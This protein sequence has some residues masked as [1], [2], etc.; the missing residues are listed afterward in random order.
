[1]SKTTNATPPRD[2]DWGERTIQSC[3]NYEAPGYWKSDAYE[4]GQRYA[5]TDIDVDEFTQKHEGRIVYPDLIIH[6]RDPTLTTTE[7]GT[8]CIIKGNKK[9]CGKSTLLKH[10]A[11]QMMSHNDERIIWR[12]SPSRS[13]WLPYRKW[14][15][16]YLPAHAEIEATWMD[17]R[18]D[19]PLSAVDD[20]GDV[21]RDVI[22]YSDIYDLLDEIGSAPGGTFNVVYPDPSFGGC[23]EAFDDT[24]RHQGVVPYVPTWE[25]TADQPP[26][27]LL[28]WWY[29]FILAR[30][31]SGPFQPWTLMI[32]E[33][34]DFTPKRTAV[35]QDEHRTFDK[36]QVVSSCLADSRRTFLSWLIACHREEQVF[37]EI[38]K[39][40]DWR[41]HMPDGSANPIKRRRSTWPPGFEHVPM[42]GDMMSSRSV[43]TALCYDQNRFTPFAWSDIPPEEGDAERWLKLS[44]LEPDQKPRRDDAEPELEFD[45]RV[46]Y[47]WQNQAKH[48]LYVNDPGGGYLNIDAAEVVEPLD[49]PLE[50][51]TFAAELR[52]RGDYRE[53]VMR[54]PADETEIVVARIPASSSRKPSDERGKEAGA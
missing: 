40:A 17:E 3:R 50:G 18:S 45:D 26:T 30:S 43:G 38:L 25:A 33:G 10:L 34:G 51:L 2:H 28:H 37:D 4:M 48:R 20:L 11:R 46:F 49:S 19:D 13:E 16:L 44:L 35:K 6:E 21:V 8:S 39:D 9:G 22:Y 12:G 52:S 23:A 27:P 29:A 5:I 32:D 53:V 42:V 24:S 1:M 41:I 47:E 31:D 14:T 54:D 36:I 15:T 7:K